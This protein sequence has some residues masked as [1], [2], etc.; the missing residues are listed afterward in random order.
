MARGSFAGELHIYEISYHFLHI[1]S[2][3][4]VLDT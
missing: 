4:L 3:W 1:H 2:V